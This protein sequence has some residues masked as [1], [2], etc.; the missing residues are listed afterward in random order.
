MGKLTNLEGRC[1][2]R[3]DAAEHAASPGGGLVLPAPRGGA[4]GRGDL[5]LRLGPVALGAGE[6]GGGGARGVATRA[7]VGEEHREAP[8]RR[9]SRQARRR[10]RHLGEVR[11]EEAAVA[12]WLAR[13]RGAGPGGGFGVR[14]RWRGRVG[15]RGRGQIT[16]WGLMR[17]WCGRL[18]V[19][20]LRFIRRCGLRWGLLHCHVGPGHLGTHLGVREMVLG[21]GRAP[22]DNVRAGAWWKEQTLC[23]W[24]AH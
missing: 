21:G 9:T 11:T 8:L 17:W 22:R 14:A 20:S 6:A 3:D 5:R 4:G 2:A 12:G 1:G 15:R 10:R 16:E 18:L 24:A 19:W 7:E 23:V 13:G